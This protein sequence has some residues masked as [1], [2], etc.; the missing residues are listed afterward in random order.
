MFHQ[1]RIAQRLLPIVTRDGLVV[2]IGRGRNL[3]G[4]GPNPSP[5]G[6][7]PT[8]LTAQPTCHF[9]SAELPPGSRAGP[10]R[11]LEPTAASRSVGPNRGTSQRHANVSGS[12]LSAALGRCRR[13]THPG[14]GVKPMP[15]GVCIHARQTQKP[16]VRKTTQPVGIAQQNL[17]ITV[18]RKR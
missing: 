14:S 9:V 4:E 13:E 5:F 15:A 12:L 10:R 8:Q 6:R 17:T 16:S 7:W 2:Q 11:N 1:G 3:A 18:L